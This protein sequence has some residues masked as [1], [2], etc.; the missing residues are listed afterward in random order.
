MRERGV[1]NSSV[2]TP[3]YTIRGTLKQCRG[4]LAPRPYSRLSLY[5]AIIV[6]D[7]PEKCI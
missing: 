5:R 6:T 3:P 7:N 1:M 2:N 4:K